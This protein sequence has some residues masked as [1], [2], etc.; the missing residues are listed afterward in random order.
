MLTYTR[1]FAVSLTIEKYNAPFITA[2]SE[3]WTLSRPRNEASFIFLTRHLNVLELSL[4]H[5]PDRH[6]V[7]GSENCQGIIIF[8]PAQIINSWVLV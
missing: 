6:N 7:R 5:R 2:Y 8:V 3:H 4:A 1:Y